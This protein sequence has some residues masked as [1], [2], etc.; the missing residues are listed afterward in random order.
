MY[1]ADPRFSAHYDGRAPQ[2]SAFVRAAI[3]ANADRAESG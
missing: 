1:V 3:V 2:L